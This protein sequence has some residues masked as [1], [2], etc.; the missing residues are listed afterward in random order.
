M[1]FTASRERAGAVPSMSLATWPPF[2]RAAAVVVS[3]LRA[4]WGFQL[5]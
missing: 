2:M 5:P 3:T 1:D 4:S